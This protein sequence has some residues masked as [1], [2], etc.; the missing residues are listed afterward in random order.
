MTLSLQRAT[1]IR[2]LAEIDLARLSPAQRADQLET[3]KYED[4]ASAPGWHDVPVAV[5]KE[6]S[7]PGEIADPC[8]RRYD[9]VLLLWLT[10]RYAAATNEFILA[11]LREAGHQTDAIQGTPVPR[12]PCPCCGLR[13]LGSR[14]QYDICP[15]CW[16]EDDGQ[17]NE[18]A[19][20]ENGG[21]NGDLSLTRA[22]V[23]FLREGISDPRRKDLRKFQEP[24]DKYE[25]GRVFRIHPDGPRV[26]EPASGWS[27]S[28]DSERQ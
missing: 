10:G 19:S 25:V 16:W 23:N 22:R 13:T 1:A 18:D 14:R 4:W 12:E 27:D 28:L 15:V 24:R 11:R 9:P 6:L 2:F 20:R 8:D 26:S 17:D 21:P 7:E 3:M 5:R